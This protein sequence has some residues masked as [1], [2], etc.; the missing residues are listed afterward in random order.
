MTN[1][2]FVA[3]GFVN[4]VKEVGEK[5]VVFSLA[6]GVKQ[7]DGTYKNGFVNCK[8]NKEKV[9][10]KE[11]D[12]VTV[13]GFPTFEFWTDKDSGRERQRM[14]VFVQEVEPVS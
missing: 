12:R 5:L 6:V 1:S 9:Q 14:V 11:G 10:I 8:A 7:E 3:T 4:N 2:N 13:K